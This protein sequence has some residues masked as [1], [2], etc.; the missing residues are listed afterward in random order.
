MNAA[1]HHILLHSAKSWAGVEASVSR[2]PS[3]CSLAWWE[4]LD[5]LQ[6]SSCQ[7][8]GL[9]GQSAG[10]LAQCSTCLTSHSLTH[11]CNQYLCCASCYPMLLWGQGWKRT[12][13]TAQ[14]SQQP[15][16]A[17]ETRSKNNKPSCCV[18]VTDLTAFIFHLH[19]SVLFAVLVTKLCPTLCDPMDCSPPVSSLHGI[20]QA[21]KLEWIAISFSR[22]SSQP[23]NWTHI[24]FIR[25]TANRATCPPM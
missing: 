20:S 5:P 13:I 16:A 1:I 15:K 19:H 24:S 23:R 14:W 6:A 25:Q 8:L 21:R 11:S 22:G 10:Q 17:S 3:L 12:K 2:T 4:V 9:R 18:P 7:G